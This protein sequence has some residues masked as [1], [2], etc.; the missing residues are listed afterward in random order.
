MAEDFL[1]TKWYMDCVSDH[2]DAMIGYIARVQWKSFALHYSS[3]VRTSPG[4]ESVIE[5]SLR[6]I[7]PPV[8]T[9][10]GNGIQWIDDRLAVHGEWHRTAP[11]VDRTLYN[12]EH[13]TIRWH[14]VMPGAS[15]VMKFRREEVAGYGYVERLE[16]SLPPWHLPI[17]TLRWGRYVQHGESVVWLDWQGKFPLTAV[18]R[19]GSPVLKAT[20]TDDAVRSE[21]G[22]V[23]LTFTR[24]H[25]IR[26]GAIAET[27]LKNVPL[28]GIVLPERTLRMN[29]EKWLSRTGGQLPTGAPD[30]FTIHERVQI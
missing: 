15:A 22:S 26:R 23:A 16:M 5:T 11:A 7:A 10:D 17:E 30:G 8:V 9:N 18:F 3:L 28:I 4:K 14:C 19:N 21:D 13:G 2:G 25:V 12:D 27:V 20:V 24:G 1:L 6:A 29:E